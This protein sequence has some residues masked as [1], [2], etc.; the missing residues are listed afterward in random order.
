MTT[1]LMPAPGV[2][3]EKVTPD[4]VQNPDVTNPET[5][6]EAPEQTDP[7]KAL[8]ERLEK[9]RKKFERRL[10]AKHA[11]AAQATERARHLEE[12]LQARLSQDRPQDEPRQFDP[13]DIDRIATE[14]AE[15]IAR[16]REVD[17]RG[18][19][20]TRS[21]EKALGTR[22]DVNALVEVITE[23]AGP[24]IDRKSGS[25]TPLGEA[26]SEADDPAALLIYLRDNEDIA[27]SL[28]GLSPAQLGRK[29]A[30]IEAELGTKK[31]EPKAS[32]APKPLE[33]V[34]AKAKSTGEPDISDT[35][36]WI[37]W[38]NAQERRR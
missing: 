2:A 11:Q 1:E 18:T 9:E 37:K 4:V 32:A 5:E 34:K 14:R 17:K 16:A 21:L 30:R 28:R 6:K 25:W 36:A 15:V 33:P 35:S 31:D 8:E 22:E 23:E 24:L 20:I 7:V 12:Q 19:E 3:A 13:A 38:R 27:A 26:I 29:V 10:N